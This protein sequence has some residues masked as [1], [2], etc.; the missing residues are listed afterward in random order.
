MRVAIFIPSYGDG[1]VERMLVNL[2]GGLV[3]RGVRIDFLTHSA[4]APYLDRLDARV[5]LVETPRGGWS[6]AR[7][8]WR[9]LRVQAPD[10]V[11]CG[12]DR[13]GLL[14]ARV[15]RLAGARCRLVM[16]PGTTYSQRFAELGAWSR[17]R[18]RAR[19]RRTYRAAD[20][21]VGNARAVVD[22]V[23]RVAG[24]P[25]ARVHLIRNPVITSDLQ[26]LA[27]AA[28]A[29]PGFGPEAPPVVLAVGRLAQVKGFD[30]LIRAFAR[31]RAHRPLKLLILGEG[32]LR[33]ALL[34]LADS[35][36]VGDDVSLPGFD[37]NPYPCL[38]HA[39]LFVLSSRREGSPNALTEALALGTP[40]VS[41]DCPSGPA[42]VLDQGR[43]A[44]LVAVDDEVALADAMARVLDAPGDPQVRR[45]AVD[46]YRVEHCAERY[47]LLFE[48]LLGETA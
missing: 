44:P 1:G 39:A 25:A 45:E 22:D 6:L 46:A 32:R 18:A 30:V 7:W 14:V 21:V 9:Y 27:A 42:E 28:P 8:L 29:Y 20:A 13:A 17:W 26:A 31:V 2:A 36:G 5:R 47:H 15:R 11:L 23:A 12:K 16:R 19:V 33:E 40:V 41:T 24:L 48:R 38:A 35:L 43:V 4:Q 34:K 3:A 37:P 10:I